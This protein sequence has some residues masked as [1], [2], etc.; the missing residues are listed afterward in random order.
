[1]LRCFDDTVSGEATM[2]KFPPPFILSFDLYY[3]P[4][5]DARMADED[6][7]EDDALQG[8]REDPLVDAEWNK[9][10]TKYSDVR[11]STT[12]LDSTWS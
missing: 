8:A 1:M 5:T 9:L 12:V 11:S 7:L 2:S 3:T 6:W 10:Q 4:R